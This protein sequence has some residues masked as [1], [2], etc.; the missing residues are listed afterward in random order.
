MHLKCDSS[1]E[2]N[3]QP[4]PGVKQVDQVLHILLTTN[5]FVGGFLGFFFDNTIPGRLLKLT[6]FVCFKELKTCL[7]QIFLVV[8]SGTKRERGLPD[9]EEEDV[10]DQ[11]LASLEI[12]DL[13]FGLT[14]LLSS[15]SWVRYVPFCPQRDRKTEVNNVVQGR[16]QELLSHGEDDCDESV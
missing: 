9:R 10:S 8:V 16:G 2:L 6:L 14:S 15:R 11:S 5:M 4:I 13:P 12:Y 1:V 7:L 3:R